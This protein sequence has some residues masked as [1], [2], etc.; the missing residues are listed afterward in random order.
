[1]NSLLRPVQYFEKCVWFFGLTVLFF[2]PTVWAEIPLYYNN[3]V[4]TYTIPGN[5]PP[6]I[7]AKAFFNDNGTFTINYNTYNAATPFYETL[8]TLFYTNTGTMIANSPLITNGVSLLTLGTADFGVGY[9]FD[10][11]TSSQNLWSDT[12]YNPGTIR[13]A[14]TIDGNNLF[15]VFT[16]FGS[17]LFSVNSFGECVVAATNII[18]PGT[19]EVSEEGLINFKGNNVNLQGGQLVV[20][21][22]LFLS[23]LFGTVPFNGFGTHGVNTNVLWNPFFSLGPNFADSSWA[24]F[25]NNILILNNSTA[26][27]DDQIDPINA[28]TIVHR[29][30][31]IQD[32]SDTN[33]VTYNVYFDPLTTSTLG[34]ELGTINVGWKA[35][36]IDPATGAP[37]NNYLYLVDNPIFGATTNVLVINGE[38]DNFE[39]FSNPSPLLFGPAPAG[40]V[41]EFPD[42]N[43]TNWYSYMNGTVTAA[44]AGTNVSFINPHGT[45][46]NLPGQVYITASNELNLA[47]TTISGPNYVNL[48]C[49]N[50]FDGSP[51]AAIATPYADISLG[52]TN[53]FLTISNVLMAHIPNWSSSSSSLQAWSTRFIT[54]DTTVTP[55][56]TND[57]RVMIVSS[58]F[59]PTTEPWVQNLYLHGTNTLVLSDPMVVYGS[60]YSDAA[61]L[62]L[63]TNQVGV[64]A[65]SL[66]GEL[67]WNNTAPLNFNSGSGLQQM[68][69][70]LWLTNSGL[71][72]AVN[73]FNDGNS[74]AAQFAV[75]PGA[76]PVTNYTSFINHSLVSDQ[77]A[78]IWT[79]YF[80]NDGTISNG[81]GSFVLHSGQA[82]LT[83]GNIVATGDV[84]LVATNVPLMG[85]NGLYV[86]NQLIQAGHALTLVA[87]NISGDAITNNNIWVVGASSGGGT[88]DSGFNIPIK[89]PAGDLLGTTVTNISPF[90]KT[91]YNV[92]AGNDYGVSA[93]GYTNNLALGHLVLDVLTTNTNPA[94]VF[95][96]A[97]VSNALYVDLLELRD[98]ARFGNSTNNYNFPWLKFATNMVI[99]Y[100]QA[101]K[102]G[103]SVAEA[104]DTQSKL[105]ANGGRLRWISSYAGHFSSTN[106]YFTNSTGVVITNTVNTALAQSKTIDSDSDG[107][108]NYYDPTPLFVSPELNFHL[109]V[110]N[111]PPMSVKV[112]WVTIPNATNFV[113]YTTNLLSTNWLPFTNF[114]N[115]YYGNNVAVTN[116]AHGNSFHSPQM[117]INNGSLPDNAQQTNVWVFDAITNVPHY[118]KVVVW[119]WLTFPE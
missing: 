52:V 4:L 3:S 50:Q 84:T 13:C 98:G 56:I 12:F 41:N 102:D 61:V 10:L 11:Q 112:Q 78:S 118:Y 40:F 29:A 28:N 7:D 109:A 1:M 57:Y 21:P 33:I 101:L 26:Y 100:A 65:T 17:Q 14:S 19:V 117:Y 54:V 34:F 35:N 24:P 60:I 108:P 8:D 15:G 9:K 81:T 93:Q 95:S 111:V 87:T 70:L 89:P 119:P 90:N 46:T 107:I 6:Q 80:E 38:P 103:Q 79:S 62:T 75:T 63:N 25:P 27:I 97:G 2:V 96:G 51:G 86:S 64:G 114:N 37:V 16:I 74:A 45:I 48:N 94:F 105:G 32:T 83:N 77:G 30:V 43:M 88:A 115:W 42:I 82:V 106:L 99:Y 59:Q 113:Y 110:T 72:S 116:S 71:I 76:T 92:W 47:F 39:F 58:A 18:N 22:P 67:V 49:T 91:V 23:G 69:N 55:N 104:I 85:M 31:F 5:P 68:P 66:D 36:Y 73:T 44:T 53:G 20:E